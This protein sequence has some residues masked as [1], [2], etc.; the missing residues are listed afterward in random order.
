MDYQQWLAKALGE[1]EKLEPGAIFEV[2]SLFFP[3]EWDHLERKDKTAFGR[4]FSN[5]YKQGNI[6]GIEKLERGK[7][8]HSRYQKI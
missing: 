7:N 3:Y 4:Y 6:D 8:N 5:E 2:K 1:I